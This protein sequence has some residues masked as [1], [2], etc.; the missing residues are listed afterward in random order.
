MRGHLQRK[1]VYLATAVAILALAGSYAFATGTIHYTGPPQGGTTV[2]T[3]P[4]GFTTAWVQSFGFGVVTGPIAA[5]QIAGAQESGTNGLAGTV[6]TAALTCATQYCNEDFAAIPTSPGGGLVVGDQDEQVVLIV[7]DTTASVGFDVQVEVMLSS[8][9]II[10]GN[11]YFATAALPTGQTLGQ[12]NVQVFLY[13]DL[14][15]NPMT[16]ATTVT[17]VAIVLNSC[18]SAT[19]CP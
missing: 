8:G 14:D 3:A 2:V 1:T 17:D 6:G 15:Y 18:S 5:T 11:G 9:T 4:T 7:N 13:L 19:V 16:V 10:F 12:A